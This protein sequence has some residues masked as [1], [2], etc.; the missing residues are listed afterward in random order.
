MKKTDSIL[1]VA[2]IGINHNGDI[3]LAKRMI[4]AAKQ[5]GA[6]AVKFQ[7]YRT[8]DFVLNKTINFKYNSNTGMVI[9]NQFEMFKRYELTFEKLKKLKSYCD[10]IEI[11]FFS[12]PTSARGIEELKLLGVDY[13]KNGSDFI[14]NLPLIEEM[15]KSKIPVVIS[16]G[17]A[18]LA[19][20]DEAVRTFENAGGKDLI[21]LHC[22]SQYPAPMKEVNLLKIPV[23][24]NVFGYPIGFSDHTEG[25]E[26]AIGAVALGATFIEKHFT[27]SHDLPGPDHQFSS[28]PD[29]FSIYVESIRNIEMALGS[30][31]L[32]PTT[33]DQKN[34]SLYHLSC[35]ARKKLNPNHVL[36]IDDIGFS[37]PGDGFPP[38]MRDFLIGRKL[39]KS[40][41][42]G[43]N[44]NFEDFV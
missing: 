9:E 40:K 10:S 22:V 29:E 37:R 24:K 25:N 12:T 16:T 34:A 38:K 4:D 7:N 44:F 33:E 36:T 8:E 21:I 11:N 42:P 3:S 20:I 28:T 41:D 31:K 32:I 14:Q 13:I 27:L 15:A 17:M 30:K 26:A 19:Q 18:N 5:S 2:E 1:I 23:L 43:V 39:L 6:D 35:V